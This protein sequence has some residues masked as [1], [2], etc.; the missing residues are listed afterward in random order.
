LLKIGFVV[1]HA[2]RIG[3]NEATGMAWV[4]RAS[5]QSEAIR[6]LIEIALAK[7]KNQTPANRVGG[8]DPQRWRLAMANAGGP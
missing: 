7:P 2:V 6:R 5:L 4:S 3:R 1:L 8:G